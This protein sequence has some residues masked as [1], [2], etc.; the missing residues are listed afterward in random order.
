MWLIPGRRDL[1]MIGSCEILKRRGENVK[2]YFRDKYCN[3]LIGAEI[4]YVKE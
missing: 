1:A 4:K 3:A 2:R